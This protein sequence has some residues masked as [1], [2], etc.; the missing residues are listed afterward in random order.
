MRTETI[1]VRLTEIL[2]FHAGI[3]ARIEH[4]SL[5]NLLEHALAEYLSENYPVVVNTVEWNSD[6]RQRLI[7]THRFYPHVLNPEELKEIE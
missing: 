6:K 2:K 1:G 7:N 3:V 4:R 5:S